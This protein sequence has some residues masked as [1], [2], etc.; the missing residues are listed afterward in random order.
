MTIDAKIDKIKLTDEKGKNPI[1]AAYHRVAFGDYHA[2]YFV[3]GNKAVLSSFDLHVDMSNGIAYTDHDSAARGG[4]A[5]KMLEDLAEVLADYEK[6]HDIEL[7]APAKTILQN[8]GQENPYQA[9]KDYVHTFSQAV[10]G[11]TSYEDFSAA[12]KDF[13]TLFKIIENDMATRSELF[14]PSRQF[15]D[16]PFDA[17]NFDPSYLHAIY[18]QLA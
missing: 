13:K 16:R 14:T 15:G 8:K 4:S 17:Q 9:I 18:R 10:K 6:R 11:E 5:A 1:P 7:E 12:I 3:K 2:K